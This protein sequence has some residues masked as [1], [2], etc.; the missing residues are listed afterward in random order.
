M[1]VIN[2]ERRSEGVKKVS[3]W[4]WFDFKQIKENASLKAIYLSGQQLKAK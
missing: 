2:Q 4:D 1:L 3:C